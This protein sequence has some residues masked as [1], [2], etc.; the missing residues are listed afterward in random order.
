MKRYAVIGAGGCGRGVMP[1]VSEQISKAVPNGEYDLVFV[2]EQLAGK[3]I[4]GRISPRIPSRI[5]AR[6]G[7][8]RDGESENPRPCQ[9]RAHQAIR[10]AS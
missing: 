3:V 2:D 5:C 10:T 8:S 1:F 4:N 6:D 9:M 7:G